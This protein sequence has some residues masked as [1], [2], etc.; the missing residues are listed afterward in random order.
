MQESTRGG[1]DPTTGTDWQSEAGGGDEQGGEGRHGGIPA[2]GGGA[3]VGPTGS[4]PGTCKASLK[5]SRGIIV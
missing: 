4:M 5:S 3:P 2:A 1:S